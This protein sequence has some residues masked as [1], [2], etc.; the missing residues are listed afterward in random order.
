[1]S[2]HPNKYKITML[3]IKYKNEI[4]PSLTPYLSFNLYGSHI[5]TTYNP[6]IKRQNNIK[7]LSRIGGS[8]LICFTIG[9]ISK[10]IDYFLSLNNQIPKKDMNEKKSHLKGSECTFLPSKK[11]SICSSNS[12]LPVN[13]IFK[14]IKPIS[15]S[16]FC[17]LLRPNNQFLIF[18]IYSFISK[19]TKQSN[20]FDNIFSK[21][22]TDFFVITICPHLAK[23]IPQ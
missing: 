2:N 12:T 3:K 22:N 10:L 6:P 7:S 17:V 8:S 16:A 19:L 9:S 1:M 4:L 13:E 18:H 11:S 14:Q 21:L 5:K 15:T 23:A 20:F